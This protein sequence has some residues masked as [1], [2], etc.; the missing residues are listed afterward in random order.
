MADEHDDTNCDAT[1]TDAGLSCYTSALLAYLAEEDPTASARLAYSARLAIQPAAQP[2][3]PAFRHHAIALDQ[4]SDGTV[5][6]PKGALRLDTALGALADEIEAHGR[7]LF[8]V[9]AARLP[10]A[11]PGQEPAPHFLVATGHREGE[12]W[13]LHDHFSGL[14]PNGR[15]QVPFSGWVSP[16]DMAALFTADEAFSPVQR[17]R[18]REVFGHVVPALPVGTRQ[19]FTRVPAG[20]TDDTA[21]DGVWITDPDDVS[22]YL[23]EHLDAVCAQAGEPAVLEDLWAASRH[24]QYKYRLLLASPCP[25]RLPQ[26]ERAL[27]RALSCWSGLPKTLRFAVNSARRGRPRTS[28]I[29]TALRDLAAA[30]TEARGL[31]GQEDKEQLWPLT[32]STTT[33]D[34]QRSTTRNMRHCAPVRTA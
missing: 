1:A 2:E 3:P 10:W 5:L 24:H 11:P 12:F 18:S 34:E 8:T 6:Q 25:E 21:E 9:D 33:S 22:G 4:L 19:W 7:V 27:R 29:D 14:F 23:V 28:L 32:P 13:Q 30:E 31:L 17:R 16:P 26:R 20:D 15:E